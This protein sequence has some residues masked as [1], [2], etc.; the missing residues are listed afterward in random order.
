MTTPA[1]TSNDPQARTAV[2]LVI[3]V[4]G[5]LPKTGAHLRISCDPGKLTRDEIGRV[6]DQLHEAL[7]AS[8]SYRLV[9]P[10]LELK[11][12][13]GRVL[14]ATPL[15]ENPDRTGYLAMEI[16]PAME[17]GTVDAWLVRAA[18]DFGRKRSI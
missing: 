7:V 6:R 16:P 4:S 10:F 18:T 1:A 11:T 2:S 8:S 12:E 5:L 17:A 14:R 9:A 15:V 13:D 3:E